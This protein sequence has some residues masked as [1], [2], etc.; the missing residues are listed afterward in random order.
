M[1]KWK[2]RALAIKN[3][4]GNLTPRRLESLLHVKD[5]IIESTRKVKKIK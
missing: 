3:I 1:E 2:Y 4:D 5:E